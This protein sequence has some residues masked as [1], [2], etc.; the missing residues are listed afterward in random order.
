MRS[1]I[2][3]YALVAEELGVAHIL[4]T[5]LEVRGGR[6]TGR[7]EPPQVIGEGKRTVIQRFL[8]DRRVDPSRCYAYGDH[9]SDLPMLESVGH[10]RVIA[11]DPELDEAARQRGWQVLVA[12]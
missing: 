1:S 3:S 5:Q 2:R 4:A 8:D 9:S 10:P 12:A 6:Y 11:G 7:I